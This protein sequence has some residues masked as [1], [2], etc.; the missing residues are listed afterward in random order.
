MN[1]RVES[2]APPSWLVRAAA[3]F[4]ILAAAGQV[5]EIRSELV[6]IW[7]IVILSAVG[8]A[9][10]IGVLLHKRWGRWGSVLFLLTQIVDLTLVGFRT[11]IRPGLELSVRVFDDARDPPVAVGLNLLAL[12]ALLVLVNAR[13]WFAA[14]ARPDAGRAAPG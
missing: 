10:G 7:I 3:I 11:W 14:R 9:A 2:S 6:P 1:V 8:V 12:G 5:V 13:E 4:V